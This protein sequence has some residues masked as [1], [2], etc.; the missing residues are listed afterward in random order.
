MTTT[1]IPYTFDKN[2]K[3]ASII[4]DLIEEG[5]I[6]FTQGIGLAA[7][8]EFIANSSPGNRFNDTDEPLSE[9]AVDACQELLGAD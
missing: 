4:N 1:T 5:K 6:T 3:L 7:A 8:V 9:F 2:S